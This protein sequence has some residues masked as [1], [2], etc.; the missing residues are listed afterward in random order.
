MLCYGMLCSGRLRFVIMCHTM[1]AYVMK[2]YITVCY[3][4]FTSVRAPD[5]VPCFT[6]GFNA[7]CIR[8]CSWFYCVLYFISRCFVPLDLLLC[9]FVHVPVVSFALLRPGSSHYSAHSCLINAHMLIMTRTQQQ[10]YKAFLYKS[11]LGPFWVFLLLSHKT[12]TEDRAGT[13]KVIFQRDVDIYV[14]A[15]YLAALS[16]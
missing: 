16:C 8:Y 12:H 9:V 1:L 6:V 4:M 13:W 11:P 2:L 3:S 14:F 5:F 15:L 7:Q 10:S